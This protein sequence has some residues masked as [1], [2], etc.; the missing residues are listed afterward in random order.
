MIDG[1]RSSSQ[2]ISVATQL[3]NIVYLCRSVAGIGPAIGKHHVQNRV[4][5]D[6][7]HYFSTSICLHTVRFSIL[8]HSPCIRKNIGVLD[9]TLH[10]LMPCQI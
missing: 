8:L 1:S 10:M 3:S 9:F 4:V 7:Y 5:I 6:K 2:P